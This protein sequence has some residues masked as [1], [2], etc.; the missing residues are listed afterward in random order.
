MVSSIISV[1]ISV[2]HCYAKG[3]QIPILDRDEQPTQNLLFDVNNAILWGSKAVGSLKNSN[4]P[5]HEDERL[6]CEEYLSVIC[7]YCNTVTE[8]QSITHNCAEN[9]LV[10]DNLKKYLDP[11]IKKSESWLNT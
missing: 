5:R 3:L 8:S 11:L 6:S 1:I 10:D 7:H 4:D 9:I 2:E